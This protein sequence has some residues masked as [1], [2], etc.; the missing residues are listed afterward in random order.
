M[1]NGAGRIS[2]ELVID[3]DLSV[4]PA[5]F[6]LYIYLQSPYSAIMSVNPTYAARAYATLVEGGKAIIPTDG[7]V[8]HLVIVRSGSL[9]T[10]ML[11]ILLYA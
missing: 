6:Y 2:I 11:S 1:H 4:F 5:L 9:A 8:L 7:T 3:T 10:R